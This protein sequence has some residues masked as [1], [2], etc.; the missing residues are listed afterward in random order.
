MFVN[1]S[2]P[3]SNGPSPKAIRKAQYPAFSSLETNIFA[4]YKLGPP[5]EKKVAFLSLLSLGK[6]HQLSGPCGQ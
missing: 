2:K 6:I 1:L 3:A 5:A 4:P